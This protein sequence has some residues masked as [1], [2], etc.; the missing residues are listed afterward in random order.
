MLYHALEGGAPLIALV[1]HDSH[2]GGLIDGDVSF[3]W[4]AVILHFLDKRIQI[5]CAA[6]THN[7]TGQV[8]PVVRLFFEANEKIVSLGLFAFT[9]ALL[10]G[11]VEEI[12]P[13]ANH[14]RIAIFVKNALVVIV[15]LLKMCFLYLLLGHDAQ[16]LLVVP[17]IFLL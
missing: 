13:L 6:I 11:L 2:R 12:K 4:R 15:V 17:G 5:D 1:L 14:A 3:G 16:E 7:Y 10:V 8:T 9:I